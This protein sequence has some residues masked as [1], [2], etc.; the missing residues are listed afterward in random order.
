MNYLAIRPIIYNAT[1]L[2]LG[3][4]TVGFKAGWDAEWAGMIG[5]WKASETKRAR[6]HTSRPCSGVSWNRFLRSTLTRSRQ[7]AGT[8]CFQS[9]SHLSY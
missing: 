5:G 8:G 6:I 2:V 1:D 7:V 3:E 4:I 9:P